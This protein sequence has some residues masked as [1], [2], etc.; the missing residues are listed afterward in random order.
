MLNKQI[1]NYSYVAIGKKGH[2]ITG[3]IRGASAEQLKENFTNKGLELL[4]LRLLESRFTWKKQSQHSWNA[5]EQL[6]FLNELAGL[7]KANLPVLNCL[8]ILSERSENMPQVMNVSFFLAE[9][10][11]QGAKLAEAMKLAPL[12][13]PPLMITIIEAGEASSNLENAVRQLLAHYANI[14]KM[15]KKLQKALVYP[16]IVLSVSLLVIGVLLFFVIPKFETIFSDLLGEGAQLPALTHFILS[17]AHF[18]QNYFLILLASFGL[19]TLIFR[20]KITKLSCLKKLTVLKPINRLIESL[21]M[22]VFAQTMETL[23]RAQV[24]LIESVKRTSR[25][26]ESFPLYQKKWP[27]VLSRLNEGDPLG[28]VLSETAVL[29]QS[30]AIMMR[31]GD[32]TGDFP[33]VLKTITLDYQEKLTLQVDN[34]TALLEPTV[35]IALTLLVGTLIVAMFLP[36]ISILEGLT[37]F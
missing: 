4:Q 12:A 1:Q 7:L 19:L 21:Y 8:E 2:I 11:K 14:H 34:L 27:A 37:H 35:I 23:L 10:I 29:P 26:L 30:A 22:I 18:T 5:T 15:K 6:F 24:P 3:K 36:I 20:K 17:L 25:A 13:C 16:A 32:E 33:A 31:I 28:L 9:A